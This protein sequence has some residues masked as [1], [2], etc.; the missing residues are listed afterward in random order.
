MKIGKYKI[1][2]TENDNVSNRPINM[3][4]YF[5]TAPRKGMGFTTHYIKGIRYGVYLYL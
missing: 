4:F 1:R 5:F 3:G 2:L